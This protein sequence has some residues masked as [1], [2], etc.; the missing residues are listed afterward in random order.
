MKIKN[1]LTAKDWTAG[2]IILWLWGLFATV[3]VL[4]SA[5][6]VL[7]NVIFREGVERGAM[8]GQNE[9]IA[10]IIQYSQGC[11]TVNLFL[12]EGENRVEVGLVDVTCTPEQVKAAQEAAVTP[13][14][15]EAP[16]VEEEEVILDTEE[17][18]VEE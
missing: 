2:R 9:S 18:V 7:Q 11:N 12:G 3:F 8:L 4:Y 1:P 10:K 14:E 17:D 15:V 5:W 13:A 6:G 16:A